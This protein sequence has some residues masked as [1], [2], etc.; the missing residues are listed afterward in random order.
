MCVCLS[1]HGPTML[2]YPN[3]RETR[4]ICTSIAERMP[5]SGTIKNFMNA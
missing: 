2:D 5:F 1:L 4:S 3:E